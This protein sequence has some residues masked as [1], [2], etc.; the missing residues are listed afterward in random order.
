M[1]LQEEVHPFLKIFMNTMLHLITEL[2]CSATDQ[3]FA[4]LTEGLISFTTD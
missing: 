1:L 4:K 3:L 2:S